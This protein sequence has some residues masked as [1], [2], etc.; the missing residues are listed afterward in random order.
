M[1]ESP[2]IVGIVGS[3]GRLGMAI[4]DE[5]TRCG[6][7]LG[8][9]A[10]SS[11]WR[12][13]TAPHVLVDATAP[14]A[15]LDTIGYCRETGTALIYAV[16]S[17]P[18]DAYRTLVELSRQVPVVIAD[19][20]SIGHWLQVSL[21]RTIARLSAGFERQPRMSVLERHPVTKR[22]RPSASAGSL[23]RSWA[24]LAVTYSHGEIVSQRAGA[25]VSDHMVTFDLPGA[26]L[27]IS[28]SVADLRAAA[29]GFLAAARYAFERSPGLATMFD[30]YAG[31]YE[32]VRSTLEK[33]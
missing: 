22:D 3:T 6:V 17:V 31:L 24:E 23:A 25:P 8:L 12:I 28:H 32:P 33:S 21:V 13:D 5:C 10:S 7:R 27:S 19:N 11:G 1:N 4:A 2:L 14:S 9:R 16:S 29:S 26:S 18:S 20:L 15:L 30:V